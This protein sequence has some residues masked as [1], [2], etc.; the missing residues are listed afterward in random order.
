MNICERV[1]RY[2]VYY[3]I[4]YALRLWY[5]KNRKQKYKHYTEEH[6]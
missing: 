1:L 6:L 2:L 5:F 4:I 3:L